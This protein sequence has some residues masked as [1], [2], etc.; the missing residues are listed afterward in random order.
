VNYYELVR[1]L[2]RPTHAQR[3]AMARSAAQR[4]SW[5]KHLPIRPLVPFR[6][7]I[8]PD[9]PLS[10]EPGNRL[11]D[12]RYATVTTAADHLEYFGHWV[13]DSPYAGGGGHVDEIRDRV[14]RADNY[15]A[16]GP[17]GEHVPMPREVLDAGIAWVNACIDPRAARFPG[18]WTSG[19]YGLE[20][21]LAELGQPMTAARSVLTPELITA[22]RERM[23]GE[24]R[25]AMD[26]VAA[27]IWD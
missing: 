18:T 14:A 16:I 12:R 4:H 2:P 24:M 11:L 21:W 6:F 15:V 25:A 27:L 23:L 22:E 5:Y 1:P 3:D 26:R 19:G 17:D 8:A 10:S 20:E 7:F 9:A 13:C